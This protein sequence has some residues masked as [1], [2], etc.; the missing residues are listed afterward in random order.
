M[1]LFDGVGDVVDDAVEAGDDAVGGT[2]DLFE[3]VA[4]W[5]ESTREDRYR[6]YDTVA[7]GFLPGGKEPAIAKAA[8]DATDAATDV[9]GD[10]IGNVFDE[11][12]ESPIVVLGLALLAV[13]VI[14]SADLG[15]R[16][17]S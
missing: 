2:V 4:E 11:L 15:E 9:P 13:Y 12:S 5:E 8:G 3:G 16:S 14:T 10:V 6:L 17:T 7:L 1:G